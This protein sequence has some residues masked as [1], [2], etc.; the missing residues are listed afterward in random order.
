MQSTIGFIGLGVMG[1][2]MARNLLKSGFELVV[3]NRSKEKC[4][5]IVKGRFNYSD[6]VAS[7]Q[8]KNP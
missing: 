3:W 8:P 5:D 6:K 1:Q 7:Q 4:E 2:R